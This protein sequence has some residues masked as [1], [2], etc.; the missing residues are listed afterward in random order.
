MLEWG[1]KEQD[2]PLLFKESYQRMDVCSQPI[3]KKERLPEAAMSVHT[4]QPHG[5]L[6]R[7]DESDIPYSE[8][9]DD[10]IEVSCALLLRPFS[11]SAVS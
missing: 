11:T 4:V 3:D 9:S 8:E 1:E 5:K 7:E 6:N 10:D 2:E